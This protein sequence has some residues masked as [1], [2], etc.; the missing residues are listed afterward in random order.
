MANA[1]TIDIDGVGK[2]L[3]ERSKRARRVVIS[4]KPFKGIRIA[5]PYRVS[6]NK[7]EEF[8]HSKIDWIKI[9]LEKMKQ[10]EKEYDSRSGINEVIDRE[11]AEKVLSRRLQ[12]L[13]AKHRFVYNRAFFRNQRTRWGSCSRKNN[14]SLNMKLIKLPDE[15]IDYVI[16]HELVHTH[17]KDHSKVF[18]AEMDKLVGDGKKMASRLRKCGIGLY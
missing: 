2:V 9:Q 10:Y 15:L 11:K 1:N 5:V 7:A 18:W 13:A 4:V 16:L 8:V 12:Q 17:R 14:I 6:F 3:F